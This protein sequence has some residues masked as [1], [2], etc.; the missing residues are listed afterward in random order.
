LNKYVQFY[1]K[2]IG[3]LQENIKYVPR[4]LSTFE[5]RHLNAM[6]PQTIVS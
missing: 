2:L 4:A 6:R 1:Q 5:P 3:F